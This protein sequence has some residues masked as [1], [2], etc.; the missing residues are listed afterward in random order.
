MVI[1]VIFR[2]SYQLVVEQTNLYST[3]PNGKIITTNA[4]EI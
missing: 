4:L 1:E 2:H 3:Q